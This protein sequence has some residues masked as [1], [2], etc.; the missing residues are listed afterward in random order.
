MTL[1][2]Y[3]LLLQWSLSHLAILC[4]FVVLCILQTIVLP[5]LLPPL[6]PLVWESIEFMLAS[7]GELD[8]DED[9]GI[10]IASAVP[11]AAAEAFGGMGGGV[12][13][14]ELDELGWKWWW[15]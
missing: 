5:P 1:Q 11:A 4:F 7:V 9:G 8:E 2:K 14:D 12:A 13:E 15:W 3:P 10:G 6:P